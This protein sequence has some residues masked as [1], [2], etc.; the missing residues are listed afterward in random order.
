MGRGQQTNGV[1]CILDLLDM[2]HATIVITFGHLVY[3]CDQL[4]NFAISPQSRHE[5]VPSKPAARC[6]FD[7]QTQHHKT[8]ENP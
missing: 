2:T 1:A 3:L 8:C 5:A 7:Y 6:I 4:V